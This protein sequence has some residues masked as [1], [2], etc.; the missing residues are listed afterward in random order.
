MTSALGLLAT[1]LLIALILLILF[2]IGLVSQ[3]GWE[4]IPEKYRQ[5][6]RKFMDRSY[7]WL[8][9]KGVPWRRLVHDFRLA[10]VI[11]SFC[12]I[13]GLLGIFLGALVLQPSS[14]LTF[15][16]WGLDGLAT[17]G[18]RLGLYGKELSTYV[19]AQVIGDI[20]SAVV[21]FVI[22]VILAYVYFGRFLR[23]GIATHDIR[24]KG[25]QQEQVSDTG[26]TL[27][28][29]V[30]NNKGDEPANNCKARVTFTR[31]TRRD[32]LDLPQSDAQY[33]SQSREF[34]STNYFSS[35]DIA[36]NIEWEGSHAYQTILSG[37]YAMLPVVRL[38]PAR[39][40]IPEHFEV[41]SWFHFRGDRVGRRLG[42]CLRPH[43]QLIE[44]RIFPSEGKY[45]KQ[46]VCNSQT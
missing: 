6:Y 11:T 41:Q 18:N 25:R 10:V 19:V 37:D 28:V 42:I 21:I 20:V 22:G 17:L 5:Q 13:L 27:Y 35:T 36:F 14:V 34:A 38:I 40:D 9:K 29:L 32:V 44:I 3:E 1:L 24:I 46:A 30:S 23:G 12:A 26:V 31:L 7:D 45:R 16:A 33:T 2:L 43:Q 39:G 4:W 8:T 15:V